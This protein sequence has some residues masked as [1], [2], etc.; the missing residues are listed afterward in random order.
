M[1][2]DPSMSVNVS[3]FVPDL[4]ECLI[5]LEMAALLRAKFCYALFRLL[6][7]RLTKEGNVVEVDGHETQEQPAHLVGRV[8]SELYVARR[9]K[10]VGGIGSAVVINPAASD[11]GPLRQ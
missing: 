7:S 6:D 11:H 1:V 9:G 2:V 10:R 3:V 4:V 5:P 8:G